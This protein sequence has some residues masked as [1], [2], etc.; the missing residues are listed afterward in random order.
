MRVLGQTAELS[1]LS[2]WQSQG[3]DD[4]SIVSVQG[5]FT[6]RCGDKATRLADSREGG[7]TVRII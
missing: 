4:I 6:R 3:G 2:C 1:G 5:A 7:S